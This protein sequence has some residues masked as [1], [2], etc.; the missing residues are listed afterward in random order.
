MCGAVN[1]FTPFPSMSN[2]N[3]TYA[4]RLAVLPL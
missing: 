3:G 1:R 2:D 4:Y